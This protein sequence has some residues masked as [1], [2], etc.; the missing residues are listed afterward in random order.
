MFPENY[1]YYIKPATEFWNI[2]IQ[3]KMNATYIMYYLAPG[4]PQHF[5]LLFEGHRWPGEV[6]HH[7]HCLLQGGHGLHTDV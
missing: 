1:Q 7:H 2:H 6:P 3:Q 4:W 5:I